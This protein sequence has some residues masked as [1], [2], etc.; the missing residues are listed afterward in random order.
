MND[1]K[2]EVTDKRASV[3]AKMRVA[4]LTGTK[5]S[6]PEQLADVEFQEIA[7]R[8][9][10]LLRSNLIHAAGHRQRQQGAIELWQLKATTAL[11]E[12]VKIKRSMIVKPPEG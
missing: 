6:P 12:G 7:Q 3:G 2:A 4:A 11:G 9:S 10:L 5:K 8:S 1:E